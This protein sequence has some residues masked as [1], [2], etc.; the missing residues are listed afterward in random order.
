MD[1]TTDINLGGFGSGAEMQWK[2]VKSWETF[3]TFFSDA[4]HIGAVT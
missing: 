3:T 1:W 4:V 2:T